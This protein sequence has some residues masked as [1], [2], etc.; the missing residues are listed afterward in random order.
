ME[1]EEIVPSGALPIPEP[2]NIWY[3]LLLKE[4]KYDLI[5]EFFFS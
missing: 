1:V 4:E 2:P 3:L 5:S